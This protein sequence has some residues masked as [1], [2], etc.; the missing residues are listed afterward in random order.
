MNYLAHV[1]LSSPD[2]EQQLGSLIA[3]FTRGQL[4]T[5]A[6]VYPS[7]IMKGIVLHRQI[8]RF[9]D[10][11]AWVLESKRLFAG[12]QRRYAGIILD[13]LYDHFLNRHWDQF[14]DA[15]RVVFIQQ[16]Y[17]L[18]ARERQRLPVR[19]QRL[20]PRIIH[21]DWMGSYHDLEQLGLVY[22][23]MSLRLSRSNPLDDAL[24]EV[25]RHYSALSEGFHQFFPELV[26]FSEQQQQQLDR[27]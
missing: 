17:A 4:A 25:K 13:I 21:E 26:A 23:R 14:S 19:L 6:K 22:R 18:L 9:T 1:F 27:E 3:D 11:N 12:K 24:T 10:D 16:F 7:G 15:D 2:P 8:D 5:L 20:V